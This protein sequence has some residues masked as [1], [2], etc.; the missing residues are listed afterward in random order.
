MSGCSTVVVKRE[1]VDD[2]QMT[3]GTETCILIDGTV[4]RTPVAEIEIET[5]QSQLLRPCCLGQMAS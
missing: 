3:G 5:P 1:L 4:K 2:E